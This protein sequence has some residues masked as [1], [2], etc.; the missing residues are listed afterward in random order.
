[1]EFAVG[2]PL[3]A[4]ATLTTAGALALSPITV[5]PPTVHMPGLSSAL[6]STQAVQLT[7]AWS[8]LATNTAT[9]VVNLAT[10]FIGANSNIPLPSPTIFLAPI[11]TQ[12][13]LNQLIYLGQLFSGQGNQIPGEIS[14]HLTNLV[15]IASEIANALPQ[16][17]VGTLQTPIFAIQEAISSISTATNPLIGLLEAPAVFLNI[18][19]NGQFGLLGPDGLIGFPIIVRNAVAKAIDPPLPGWLAHI[20]QPGKAPSAAALTP[21]ATTVALEVAAPSHSASSNRSRSKTP[22][23]AGS[24]RK[25]SATTSNKGVGTGHGKRG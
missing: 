11:A 24:S 8:E 9:S 20:L 22:A 6:T 14:T 16:L 5:A 21:K 23:A 19:L 13:V 25:A 15:T 1:M 3:L 10:A 7:D 12:L 2:R 17:I 4:A 18:V